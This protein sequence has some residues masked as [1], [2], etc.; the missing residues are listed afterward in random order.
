MIEQNNVKNLIIQAQRLGDLVMTFPLFNWLKKQDNKEIF[1]LAEEKFYKEL[2]RISPQVTYIPTREMAYL[3]KFSYDT[4]INLS[5][6]EDTAKL[7]ASLEKKCL[8]GL[9]EK[10]SCRQ[11]FGK[12]QLYRA[13][14]THNNHYNRLHWADLN[15]LDH[16]RPH[17]IQAAKWAV[18]QGKQNGKIGLFVGASEEAKRPSIDFWADLALQ[19]NKKGYNPIFISGPSKEEQ[20]IAYAAAKK[21]QMPHG[22]IPGSLSIVEL[23]QFIES[24]QLF[25]C[26]DT[27]PM[28]AASFANVPTLNLS[29]GPVHPWETAPSPPHHYVIRSSLSC[30]GC[31]QCTKKE[32]FCRR[33]FIPH[34]IATLVHSLLLQKQLP[35]IPGITLFKTGR[36]ALGLYE[37]EAV[38]GD[39]PYHSKQA[40]FW[41]YF[42]LYMLSDKNERYQASYEK[43]KAGLFSALPQLIPPMQKA[44]LSMIKQLL[45]TEKTNAILAPNT[46][47]EF[48]PLFRPLASYIQLLL[49]NGN[50]SKELRLQ[51][52][53]LLENF[54]SALK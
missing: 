18:P 37:L 12:W 40:D 24:L 7:T 27:G 21:A 42:F 13:S 30:S 48:P 43:S 6:R 54:S 35:R 9:E 19:L 23:I 52:M 38:F 29:L 20:R 3:K 31:W 49:E 4:I 1:V 5:H 25:I 41:R 2:L 44:Y 33:A 39:K 15:A 28:H 36:N 17:I 22:V 50:Y 46:W 26:P 16:I 47:R 11:I 34:R 14:L 51:A 53:E 8:Y 32:Q 45:I 10:N